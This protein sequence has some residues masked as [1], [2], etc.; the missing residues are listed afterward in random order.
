MAVY[1][2]VL[3]SIKPSN[4]GKKV[5]KVNSIR[6][7]RGGCHLRFGRF[8]I[9]FQDAFAHKTRKILSFLFQIRPGEWL[10][11]NFASVIFSPFLPNSFHF[12]F[13]KKIT[14]IDKLIF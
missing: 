5:E 1:S 7:L 10:Y 2:I 4:F 13:F 11:C 9:S 3:G 8:L 6:Y 14:T 12:V